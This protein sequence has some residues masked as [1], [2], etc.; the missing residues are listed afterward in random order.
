MICLHADL[1]RENCDGGIPSR[2]IVCLIGKPNS[3]LLNCAQCG[4]YTPKVQSY[5][6]TIHPP[7]PAKSAPPLQHIQNT[8]NGAQT[9]RRGSTSELLDVSRKIF[10]D[11]L[12]SL[13]KGN[14]PGCGG[15]NSAAMR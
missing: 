11:R 1:G 5:Q 4:D 13:P 9:V 14:C 3:C 7:Q 12:A 2:K 10:L 6:R 15:G 8:S